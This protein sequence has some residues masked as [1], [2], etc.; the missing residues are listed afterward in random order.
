MSL[1]VS[2]VLEAVTLVWDTTKRLASNG[3]FYFVAIVCAAILITVAPGS[4]IV[5]DDIESP[6]DFLNRYIQIIASPLPV[7]VRIVQNLDPARTINQTYSGF[8]PNLMRDIHDAT[9]PVLA[10]ARCQIKPRLG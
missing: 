7:V 5:C 3:R 1:I 8:F 10:A 6:K 9:A 4:R 2:A